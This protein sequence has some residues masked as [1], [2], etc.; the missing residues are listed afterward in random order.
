MGEISKRCT[1]KEVIWLAG[2]ALCLTPAV[3]ARHG[4]GEARTPALVLI[5]ALGA[6]LAT[7]VSETVKGKVNNQPMYNANRNIYPY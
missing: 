2:K 5:C 7:L 1:I 4:A 6:V 3:C